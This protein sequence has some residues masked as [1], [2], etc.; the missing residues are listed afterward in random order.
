MGCLPG[1]FVELALILLH[2]SAS[3]LCTR[4]HPQA[5]GTPEAPILL[6]HAL[7][8]PCATLHTVGSG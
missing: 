1:C 3:M 2:S 7:I 6:S 4:S 8:P 5:L